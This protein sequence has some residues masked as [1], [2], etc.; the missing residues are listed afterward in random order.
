MTSTV[1]RGGTAFNDERSYRDDERQETITTR[2]IE[3][4]KQ[5]RLK[6]AA[7]ELMGQLMAEE[8]ISNWKFPPKQQ[9]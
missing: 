6:P 4:H 2:E 8:L 7:T 5:Q 9:A 1:L 3:P